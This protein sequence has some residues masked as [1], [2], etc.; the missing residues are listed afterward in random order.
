MADKMNS[1]AILASLSPQEILDFQ[2]RNGMLNLD[3]V[4]EQI[5]DTERKKI[6]QMHPYA[7]SHGKDGRWRTWVPDKNAKDGRK[8]IAK[9]TKEK[10]EEAVICYYLENDE[11]LKRK[12]MTLRDLFPDWLEYKRLHSSETTIPRVESDWKKYYENDPDSVLIISKR[13]RDLTKIELDE[14]IHKLIR[15]YDMTKVMYYNVSLIIRQMLDYAEELEVVEENLFRKVKIDSKRM[16]RKVHKKKDSTQVYTKDEQI[17]IFK[18]AWNDFKNSKRLVYRLA[19]LAV[20]FQFLTGVRIGELCALKFDDVEN[21]VLHVVR[22]LQRDSD[23]VVEHTKSHEDRDVLLTDAALDIIEVARAYQEEHGC[24]GEYI[25]STTEEALSYAETNI[26]LKKYCKRL[27]ILYRSS[28]KSRKTYISS[29]ID[30]GI[31]I[32]TIRSYAGHADER[33]T[34]FNYCF[35]RAPDAEKKMLLEKA[36]E[37]PLPS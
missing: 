25:F 1:Y 2:I 10:I 18:E 11:E 31:N 7:I 6:L 34:Y 28:H 4:R 14:W 3:D 9:S 5:V 29:L 17:M 26:L 12:R 21:G 37:T 36:L 33:T 8:K 15:K 19:P 24:K 22:M 20:M 13:V 35:D 16:F 27:N 23:K 30:A 32:N